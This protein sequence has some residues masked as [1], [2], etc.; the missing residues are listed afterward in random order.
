MD[1]K[2]KRNGLHE[3]ECLTHPVLDYSMRWWVC[4][5][6]LQKWQPASS[7]L[8]PAS[9]A[10]TCA[11]SKW[12]TVCGSLLPDGLMMAVAGVFYPTYRSLGKQPVSGAPHHHAV[13][14][15][16]VGPQIP[17]SAPQRATSTLPHA[18]YCSSRPVGK[19][20]MSTI[21]GSR[22]KYESQGKDWTQSPAITFLDFLQEEL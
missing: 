20:Q 19:L 5:L 4:E 3:Y 13:R 1:K 8:R 14:Q 16:Q 7:R 10:P 21:S 9:S 17:S 18:P 22:G 11:I 12:H 2:S 6:K 15:K